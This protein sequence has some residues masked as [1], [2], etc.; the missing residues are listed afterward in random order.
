M[1]DD[2]Y[3][4]TRTKI[5]IGLDDNKPPADNAGCCYALIY[6]QGQWHHASWVFYSY[7]V[8]LIKIGSSDSYVTGHTPYI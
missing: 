4:S 6:L 5:S 2:S 8:T 7:F 3:P 1:W